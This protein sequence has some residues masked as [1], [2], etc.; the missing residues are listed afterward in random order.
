MSSI[1]NHTTSDDVAALLDRLGMIET[2]E[3]NCMFQLALMIARISV[4]P[5]SDSYKDD[6]AQ[7]LMGL[8]RAKPKSN[9]VRLFGSQSPHDRGREMNRATA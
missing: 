7:T 8:I 4:E 3:S 2:V 1:E 5:C 9:V 6:V